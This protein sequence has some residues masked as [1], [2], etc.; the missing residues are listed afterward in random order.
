MQK[1][2]FLSSLIKSVGN[3]T[4]FPDNF[5]GLACHPMPTILQLRLNTKEHSRKVE[6]K[7]CLNHQQ[8][9]DQRSLGL[10]SDRI[11]SRGGHSNR[12]N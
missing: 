7:V 4:I 9:E 5:F 6:M 3:I 10:H 2:D 12:G 11:L 1:S 8:T